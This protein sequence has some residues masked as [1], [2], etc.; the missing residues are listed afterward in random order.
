MYF[1]LSCGKWPWAWTLIA[2]PIFVL[3]GILPV[4]NQLSKPEHTLWLG[5]LPAQVVVTTYMSIMAINWISQTSVPFK[6]V[7][8]VILPFCLTLGVWWLACGRFFLTSALIGLNAEGLVADYV[9]RRTVRAELIGLILISIVFVG[10]A[11]WPD[12]VS[13][14]LAAVMLAV[15]ILG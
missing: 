10:N 4:I 9:V 8:A 1:R 14:V 13:A 2:A 5:L 15:I 7:L 6:A 3:I 11:S 12:R